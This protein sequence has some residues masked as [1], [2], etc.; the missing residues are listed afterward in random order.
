MLKNDKRL[1]I[2]SQAERSALYLLPDFNSSQRLEYL[3]LSPEEYI[4]TQNC[5]NLHA[6]IY[7]ILQIGY[8]KAKQFFF[9]FKLKDIA[10]KR[11]RFYYPTLFS[12]STIHLWQH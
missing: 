5:P 9:R 8:F 7:C 2:L 4:L 11:H 12:K 10:K 1:T 6:K 3:T